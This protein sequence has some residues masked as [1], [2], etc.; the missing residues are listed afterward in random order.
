MCLK[1]IIKE[2]INDS[3]RCVHVPMQSIIFENLI[4][5]VS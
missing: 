3:K 5:I 4:F 1:N 2:L